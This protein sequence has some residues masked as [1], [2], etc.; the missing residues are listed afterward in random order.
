[1]KKMTMPSRFV[2]TKAINPEASWR[3]DMVT[4]HDVKSKILEDIIHEHAG[5]GH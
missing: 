2:Q 4:K 5:G 1:M 3:E